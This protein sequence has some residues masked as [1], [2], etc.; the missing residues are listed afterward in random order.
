MLGG[1]LDH[2]RGGGAEQLL[3][4][5]PGGAVVVH[6]LRVPALDD[7]HHLLTGDGLLL[8]QIRRDL[9]QQFPVFAEDLLGVLMTLTDDG[10]GGPVRR[11]I[12]LLGA[13]HGVAAVQILALD[14]A[15]GHHVELLAHT[16]PRHQ[17]PGHL[18][19]PLDVV[20][21]A[22][23]HGVAHDLLRGAAGKQCA[24]LRQDVLLGHEELLLLRQV[25]GIAQGALGMGHDGDLADGLGILLLGRH[26]SVAHLV[27]GDDALFLL[28]DDG[29]LLLGACDDRFKGGQQVVLVHGLAALAH[30]PQGRLV[31]QVGQVRAYAPGGG[32]GDL[33]QIHVLRQA[34]VPGVDLQGGKS[35][36]QV[37][38]VHGDAP[39]EAARTQ[40]GLVQ[41][42]RPV[43]GPQNDD[44]LAGVEAVQLRQQLVQGLLPLVV[45][46]EAAAVTGFADGVDLVDEN[47]AGS[48]LGGLLEQVPDPGRAHAHEHLH[49]VGAGD[50]E[51]GHVGLTG[52][53]LGQQGLA[54]TR[55]AHQ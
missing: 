52:H 53:G 12:G 4:L 11:G 41:H 35:A 33:V 36:R 43:G 8:Q 7:G 28:G 13:G 32:L 3:I 6:G 51:E 42:L 26:Q 45:A 15:Q 49:K 1:G 40:Q 50:G 38:P 22:G 54:G 23:G 10:D 18:R 47:D 20:G 19:G 16:E 55:G 17:V 46:A 31:H 39:V 37:G 14:G 34:D 2:V 44:A 21:G 5:L 29:A 48:H 27:I 30:G 9:V 24:D 25:Q